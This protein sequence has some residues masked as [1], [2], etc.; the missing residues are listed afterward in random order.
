MQKPLK[1][2]LAICV[3]VLIAAVFLKVFYVGKS[4]MVIP[5]VQSPKISVPKDFTADNKYVY[6]GTEAFG[7]KFTIPASLATSTNLSS[8]SY[9]SLEEVMASSSCSASLFFGQNVQAQNI[10]DSGVAYSFASTSDAA[11][12]NRY[13]ESVYAFPGS[14][15][16]LAVRYFIHYSV[17]ENYPAGSVK[18]FDKKALIDQF[19]GIRKSVVIIK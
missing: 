9:I 19:D 3:A 17:F 13:E 14:N 7:I 18:E 15:P 2:I 16:C 6:Q 5:S 10:V 12:G 1:I 4:P 8:D 11:A